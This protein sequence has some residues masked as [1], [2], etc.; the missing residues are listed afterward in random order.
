MEMKTDPSMRLSAGVGSVTESLRNKKTCLVE[1]DQAVM[2]KGDISR[3]GA[4]SKPRRQFGHI[5]L[6]WFSD[7]PNTPS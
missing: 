5:I 1:W 4:P 7:H 3:S 2:A 6:H